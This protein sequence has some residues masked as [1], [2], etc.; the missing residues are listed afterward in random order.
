M[1]FMLRVAFGED[2]DTGWK[3]KWSDTGKD[4]GEDGCEFRSP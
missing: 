3:K 1:A 2:S 4:Q